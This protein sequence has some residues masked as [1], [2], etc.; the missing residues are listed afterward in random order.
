M[1]VWIV[2]VYLSSCEMF[3]EV[4]FRMAT[5]YVQT[6]NVLPIPPMELHL[7]TFFADS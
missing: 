6:L 7:R 2:D 1:L 4:M 3:D 5:I